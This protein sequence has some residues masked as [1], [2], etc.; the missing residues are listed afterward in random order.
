MGNSLREDERL[1][2]P[3]WL[4]YIGRLTHINGYQSAAGPMQ[5]SESSPVR[6]RRSTTEPPN[7]LSH[8]SRGNP[9][10]APD[11]SQNLAESSLFEAKAYSPKHFM[12]IH[13]TF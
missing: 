1:S 12:N 9:D 3:C 8:V 5:T 2:W 10:Q 4:T 7:Q 11:Q 6:D 13:P